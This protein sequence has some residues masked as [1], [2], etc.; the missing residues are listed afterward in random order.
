MSMDQF[1]G[2]I[3]G[4]MEIFAIGA[5]LVLLHLASKEPPAKLLKAAG[6][7]L[8]LG[9][10]GVG[11]CTSYYWFQYQGAGHFAGATADS[12]PPR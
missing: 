11:I 7:V 5:G 8:L 6:L 9:G 1:L 4:M 12:S 2:D 3:A 10:L